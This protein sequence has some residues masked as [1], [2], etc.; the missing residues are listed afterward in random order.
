MSEERRPISF[1]MWIL[2]N[3]IAWLIFWLFIQPVGAWLLYGRFYG[4]SFST[5]LWRIRQG[6]QWLPMGLFILTYNLLYPLSFYSWLFYALLIASYILYR[7]LLKKR[8]SAY[9]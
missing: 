7:L 1:P 6:I 4:E 3:Y 5:V 9:N 2:F 8:D